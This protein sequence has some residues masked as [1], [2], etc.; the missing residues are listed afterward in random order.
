MTTFT[1]HNFFINHRAKR[2][3][4]LFQGGSGGEDRSRSDPQGGRSPLPMVAKRPLGCR[5]FTSVRQFSLQKLSAI[6]EFL[7]ENWRK[8]SFGQAASFAVDRLKIGHQ[9]AEILGPKGRK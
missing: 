4:S 9:G 1:K 6:S 2:G 3:G 8:S 5:G 7:H